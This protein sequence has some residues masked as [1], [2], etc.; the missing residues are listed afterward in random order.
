M[1]EIASVPCCVLENGR[2]HRPKIILKASP[3]E[4]QKETYG[5]DWQSNDNI[6]TQRQAD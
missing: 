3:V 2:L 6:Q 4:S 5:D 1:S